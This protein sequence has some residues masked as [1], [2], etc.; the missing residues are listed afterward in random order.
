MAVLVTRM[1][2]SRASR[3]S[4]SSTLSTRTSLMPWIRRAFIGKG[5]GLRRKN[6]L[7]LTAH[8][9]RG[10]QRSAPPKNE[11]VIKLPYFH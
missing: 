1:M 8:L 9:F 10:Y 6:F 4:G 7:K 2:A 5:L 11:L 3:I